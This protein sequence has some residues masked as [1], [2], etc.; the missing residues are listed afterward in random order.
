MSYRKKTAIKSAGYGG[1]LTFGILTT[2][3]LT[4]FLGPIG[5]ATGIFATGYCL[6]GAHED[7]KDR[8]NDVFTEDDEKEIESALKNKNYFESNVKLKSGA[9][10]P[11]L[12]RLLFGNT[13]SKKTKY[14]KK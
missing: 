13:I 1:A 2:A 14:Y 12:S 10:N 4:A 8:I 5:L 3:L 9:H 7:A 11:P 6:K